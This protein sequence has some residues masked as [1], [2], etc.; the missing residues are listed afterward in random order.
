VIVVSHAS[1]SKLRIFELGTGK[2]SILAK[3]Q[4]NV[5]V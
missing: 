3:K 2:A 5:H 1:V 4:S